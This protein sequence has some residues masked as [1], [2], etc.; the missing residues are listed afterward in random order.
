MTPETKVAELRDLM[1]KRRNELS[2]YLEKN[3]PE[4]LA[5]QKHLTHDVTPERVYWKYGYYACIHDI[6]LQLERA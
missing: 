4:V 1:M 6:L 3:A 5:E 2:A